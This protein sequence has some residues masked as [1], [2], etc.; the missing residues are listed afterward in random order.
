MKLSTRSTYGLRLMIE[1]AVRF[2]R[3]PVLLREIARTEDISEKYLSQLVIPLKG[4]GLLAAFRGAHG[5][6][7]L[8]KS[9]IEITLKDIVEP[10]EGDLGLVDESEVPENG[11]RPSDTVTRDL[12]RLL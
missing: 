5:G 10:L 4:K 7:V 8:G 2:G 9:P 12:W 3:G 11:S 1:L 6:Y